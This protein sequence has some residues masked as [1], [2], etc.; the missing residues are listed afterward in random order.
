M[1]ELLHRGCGDVCTGAT[2][3]AR[4]RECGLCRQWPCTVSTS[5]A[6]DLLVTVLDRVVLSDAQSSE[7]E[8]GHKNPSDP[9]PLCHC[10]RPPKEYLD[11]SVMDVFRA[12]EGKAENHR[13]TR[14]PVQ[15]LHRHNQESN[16]DIDGSGEEISHPTVPNLKEGW[17]SKGKQKKGEENLVNYW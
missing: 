13:Y 6:S 11:H 1:K 2:G 5:D 12:G 17:R 16:L 14:F 8:D 9:I 3:K 15:L 7:T 10:F 4:C